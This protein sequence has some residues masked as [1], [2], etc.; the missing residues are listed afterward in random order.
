MR[1]NNNRFVP[2]GII[3]MESIYNFNILNLFKN[4]HQIRAAVAQSVEFLA[5]NRRTRVRGSPGES[6]HVR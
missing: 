6:C 3:K 1:E 5:P 4:P 2:K